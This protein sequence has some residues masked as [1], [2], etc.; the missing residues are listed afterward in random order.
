LPT[1]WKD[2]DRLWLELG[3]PPARAYQIV[4]ALMA[5]PDRAIEV[6]SKRLLKDEGASEKEIRELITN[7]ASPKFAQ[8]DAAM[9]RLKV[10]GTRALPAL[11]VALKKAPDLETTRRMQ[12]LLRTVET[13][14]TPETLRDLRGLQVLEMICTPAARQ[15]LGEIAAGDPG[16]GKTRHA[17]AALARLKATER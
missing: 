12:E 3:A 2:A 13:T 9:R 6:M 17:Q 14:L 4:W 8:R 10:I 5:H 7:L 11:E 1:S 16:A 15:L